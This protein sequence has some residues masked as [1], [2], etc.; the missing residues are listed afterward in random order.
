MRAMER[1]YTLPAAMKSVTSPQVTTEQW[2]I[3]RTCLRDTRDSGRL[4]NQP[5]EERQAIA[6]A[7][8]RPPHAH[9]DE[10]DA[11]AVEPERQRRQ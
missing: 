8:T 1:A 9:F 5:I 11:I 10:Q 6:A 3:A 2:A 7:D 4:V